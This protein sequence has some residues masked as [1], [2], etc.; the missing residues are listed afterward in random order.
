MV[1]SQKFLGKEDIISNSPI[2]DKGRLHRIN[3]IRKHF[4]DPISNDFGYTLIDSVAVRNR[5]IVPHLSRIRDFR[6]QGNS[7]AIDLLK[8]LTL[9]QR[10]I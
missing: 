8:Q 7:S 3:H 9:V 10:K 4:L 5:P 2:L 6:Y 1:P